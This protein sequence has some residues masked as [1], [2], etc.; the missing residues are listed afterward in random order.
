MSTRSGRI[1]PGTHVTQI[2]TAGI[3]G[4]PSLLYGGSPPGEVTIGGDGTLECMDAQGVQQVLTVK[5]GQVLRVQLVQV[6]AAG[7]AG[8]DPL[9]CIW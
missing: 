6:F 5:A 4:N 1:A 7:S 9:T 8:V 2:W 3:V